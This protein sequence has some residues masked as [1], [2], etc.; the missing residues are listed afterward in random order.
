[1]F[2]PS[3]YKSAPQVVDYTTPTAVPPGSD[4]VAIP[5]PVNKDYARISIQGW[6]S[7]SENGVISQSILRCE[8]TDDDEI[9]IYGTGT[10]TFPNDFVATFLV[11]EY[12]PFFFHQPFYYGNGTI[13][14]NQLTEVVAT[15]LTLSSK[16]YIQYLGSSASGVTDAAMEAKL[17][18][19]V[20]LNTGNGEVTITRMRI[21]D[22]GVGDIT[23]SFLIIDPK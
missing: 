21:L 11:E 19:R 15:G 23:T 7:A 9:T 8:L 12:I 20:E 14:H 22:D 5:I 17:R 1:M 2:I 10:I 13:D 16:A 4:T 18:T 3:I 6:A